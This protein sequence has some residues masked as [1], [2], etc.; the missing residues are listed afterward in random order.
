[1]DDDVSIIV[2]GKTI[3]GWTRVRLTRGIERLPADFHIE[4]TEY[5]SGD[6]STV[7]IAPGSPCQIFLGPDV[8]LTGYVDEYS[9]SISGKSHRVS[10]YGR[11]KSEDLVDCGAEYPNAQILSQTV[12]QI[13]QAFATVPYGIP[14]YQEVIADA[15]KNTIPQTVFVYTETAV[16]VIER[17]C[18]YAKLLFYDQPDGS[19]ILT[20]ASSKKTACGFSEGF[21]IEEAH[22]RFTM[23]RYSKYLCEFS[24]TVAFSDN[25]Q[26]NSGQNN[27]ANQLAEVDDT[28]V[29]RN[30]KKYIILESGD[31]S[32][33]PVTQARALWEKNRRLGKAWE[34]VIKT[35]SWRD[36]AG[37]LWQPN[38]L[39]DLN[40]PS[41]K[42]VNQTW[43]ISEV[44]YSRDE[45][46][47]TSATLVMNPPGAFI[48]EP[49]VLVPNRFPDVPAPNPS[50]TSPS[51]T[52]NSAA[53]VQYPGVLNSDQLVVPTLDQATAALPA[54]A[55]K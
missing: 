50:A 42:I 43:L 23:N 3:A 25:L 7:V 10:L 32:P 19:I 8:V 46:N 1:M 41:L 6:N 2:G 29:Q 27:S 30:R 9:P 21:N 15:N 37:K 55:T 53:N 24:S 12:L 35:D 49:I 44:T 28:T 51:P 4:L 48:P 40:I 38:T 52:N 20:T 17:V 54:G 47:G 45:D 14:V 18:R 5:Y 22:A 11:S 36:S 26:E 33:F 34:V 31:Y 13:V 16:E 39:V